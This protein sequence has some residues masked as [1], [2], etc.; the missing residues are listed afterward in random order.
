MCGVGREEP[1]GIAPTS[2]TSATS[3]PRRSLSSLFHFPFF[4]GAPALKE[5]ESLLCCSQWFVLPRCPPQVR[6][7][8]INLGLAILIA[9]GLP[10]FGCSLEV[11]FVVSTP[12][13]VWPQMEELAGVRRAPLSC[14]PRPWRRRPRR[15]SRCPSSASSS[16]PE[17][18]FARFREWPTRF[19]QSPVR[20]GRR[21][22]QC[23]LWPWWHQRQQRLLLLPT[24]CW[25]SPPRRCE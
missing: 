14:E 18:S 24:C 3:A 22:R 4:Q 8:A 13:M 12:Q 7:F 15:R 5:S 23:C 6:W 21:R 11:A 25:Q 17:V 20:S 19:Y 1:A 16:Q 2:P 9:V 10:T